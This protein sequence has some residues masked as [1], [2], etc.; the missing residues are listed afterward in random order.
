VALQAQQRYAAAFCTGGTLPSARGSEW[1]RWDPHL[2]APGTLQA[3]EYP[4]ADGWA[5]YLQALESA[6][7]V[8]HA[9]GVTDYCV[10]R[11]YEL[12]KAA[13]EQGRLKDCSLLFPNV[14]LRLNT[15]TV[16]GNFVNIHLLVSPD[17]PNHVFELN[18]SLGRLVFSGFSDKFA[19]TPE[20]LRRLGRL[21]GPDCI[22]ALT[23]SSGVP[24]AQFTLKGRVSEPTRPDKFYGPHRDPAPQRL[25]T[26]GLRNSSE[27]MENRPDHAASRMSQ[28]R[29]SSRAASHFVKGSGT[30]TAITFG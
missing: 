10:T 28:L 26:P 7:P 9:I 23:P 14:E 2:H 30:S 6:S 29:K 3:D 25:P 27:S 5:H 13:K 21:A 17:D 4:A 12:V 11:S 1:H 8:I 20:D 18:R 19:C 16:K 22:E 15:G 24:P